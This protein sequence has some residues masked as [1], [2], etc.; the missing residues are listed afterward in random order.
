MRSFR[1]SD[2]G[3]RTQRFCS[4]AFKQASEMLQQFLQPIKVNQKRGERMMEDKVIMDNILTATKGA[5][6]LMMHGAIESSTPEVHKTFAQ[7]FDDTLCLQNQIYT[8]MSQKGWYPMQQV[9]EE[10]VVA[11]KQK[12]MGK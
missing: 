1:L 11:T 10:K 9:E 8:K 3:S 4:G 12:F 5:C 7:A 2:T 6:D